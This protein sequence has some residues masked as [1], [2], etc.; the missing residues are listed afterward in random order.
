MECAC[1]ACRSS[2]WIVLKAGFRR[3]D[4]SKVLAVATA[5]SI[6]YVPTYLPTYLARSGREGPAYIL[7][8]AILLDPR[9]V[10]HPM[11]IPRNPPQ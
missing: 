7:T 3:A 9:I 5:W 2:C 6:F 8:V 10:S 11:M 4:K 1:C